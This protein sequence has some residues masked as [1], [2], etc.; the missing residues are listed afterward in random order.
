MFRFI[1]PFVC[2]IALSETSNF[3]EDISQN[4]LSVSFQ[5]G[6]LYG[7]QFVSETL[8]LHWAL[9]YQIDQAPALPILLLLVQDIQIRINKALK[10]TP[11]HLRT[12][13]R[14]R[15]IRIN[16]ALKLAGLLT[17]SQCGLRSIL[18]EL[19]IQHTDQKNIST[20][21]FIFTPPLLFLYCFYFT[22]SIF[23]IL[24]IFI[25]YP[26]CFLCRFLVQF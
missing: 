26:Y 19:T 9:K 5:K 25:D 24:S 22:C 10:R 1:F 15:P 8:L 6:L 17:C 20:Y 7:P 4:K 12:P 14:L 18:Y 3:S 11:E 21:L 13:E 2:P 16:K 23:E